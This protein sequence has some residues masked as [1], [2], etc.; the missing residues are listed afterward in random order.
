LKRA[1]HISPRTNH[2]VARTRAAVPVKRLNL[3]QHV[4]TSYSYDSLSRLLSV[5]HQAGGAMIDG[6]SYSYD[7]AGNR[8]SK[9][10]PVHKPRV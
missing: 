2:F 9:A 10:I 5:L 6:A 7:N 1:T 4:N 8:T 3:L